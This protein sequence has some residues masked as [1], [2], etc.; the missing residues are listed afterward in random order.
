MAD[1]LEI[2]SQQQNVRFILDPSA[3]DGEGYIDV[4]ITDFGLM[5]KDPQRLLVS[6]Q[7][8]NTVFIEQRR[9]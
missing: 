2:T 3:P 7:S 9:Y 6:P 1:R 8:A 5:V 4:S